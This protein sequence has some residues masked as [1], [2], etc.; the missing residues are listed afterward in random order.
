M[1]IRRYNE[2]KVNYYLIINKYF[3]G[4]SIAGTAKWVRGDYEYRFKTLQEAY[5]YSKKISHLDFL[6]YSFRIKHSD[7]IIKIKDMALKNSSVMI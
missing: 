6:Y 7:E 3:I 1:E 2:N 4:G 5:D